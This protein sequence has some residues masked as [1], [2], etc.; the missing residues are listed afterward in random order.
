APSLNR[1]ERIEW[2]LLLDEP[3]EGQAARTVNRFV[4][5]GRATVITT[6]PE[7]SAGQEVAP[8]N[9]APARPPG[10]PQHQAQHVAADPAGQASPRAVTIEHFAAIVLFQTRERV[11]TDHSESVAQREIV[12]IVPGRVYTKIDRRHGGFLMVHNETGD[13]YGIRGYGQ[14]D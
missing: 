3:L 6:Y 14:A 7:P 9:P 4:Q 13:I 11:K 1:A 5:D 2:K 8:P 12:S 10:Q